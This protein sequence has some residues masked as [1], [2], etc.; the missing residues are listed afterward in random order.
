MAV[1]CE[2]VNTIEDV[3]SQW[4]YLDAIGLGD[5]DNKLVACGQDT[6]SNGYNELK[7]KYDRYYSHYH[8]KDIAKAMCE[9]CKEKN[10]GGLARYSS[11]TQWEQFYRCLELK[12]YT[13]K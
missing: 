11:G 5:M 6:D 4:S 8:E 10:T 2:D 13:K 9:C 12:G 3:T 7:D 1:K